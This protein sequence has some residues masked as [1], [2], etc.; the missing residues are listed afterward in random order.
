M[1][2]AQPAARAESLEPLNHISVLQNPLAGAA[3]TAAGSCIN[4]GG[5]GYARALLGIQD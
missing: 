2:G 3:F 4:V 5:N 1:L